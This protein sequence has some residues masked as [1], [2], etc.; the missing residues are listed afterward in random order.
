MTVMQF[1]AEEW[2]GEDKEKYVWNNLSAHF[3][4]GR[5]FHNHKETAHFPF[6]SFSAFSKSHLLSTLFLYIKYT[7]LRVFGII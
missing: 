1:L 4:R 5:K 6:L 2:D 3:S 7:L